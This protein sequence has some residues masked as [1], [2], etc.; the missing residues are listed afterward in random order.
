IIWFT[1][2]LASNTEIIAFLSSGVSFWR[3]LRPYVIG[4]T[5]VCLAALFM[6]TYLAP[7]ASKG[8]NEFRY[9][10]LKS[11]NIKDTDDVFRQINDN[12]FIYTSNF[13]AESNRAIDFILEHFEEDELKFKITAS[14]LRYNEE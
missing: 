8:Y 2:K 3:F 6:S 11:E 14:S 10:Y 7:E 4:A 13:R 12:E 9:K 1:S 5:I